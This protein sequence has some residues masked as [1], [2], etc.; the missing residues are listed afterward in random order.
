MRR[1]AVSVLAA[2]IGL[3]LFGAGTAEVVTAHRAQAVQVQGAVDLYQRNTCLGGKRSGYTIMLAK[4]N[5][6]YSTCLAR[7][8]AL[9]LPLQ[10]ERG[11]PVVLWIDRGSTDVLGLRLGAA[12]GGAPTYASQYLTYPDQLGSDQRF[13][14]ALLIAFGVLALAMGVSLGRRRIGS[15]PSP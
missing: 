7:F 1:T 11:T 12:A 8:P 3:I 5:H 10:V 6:P 9:L 2:V 15:G 4:D 13:T 14:G